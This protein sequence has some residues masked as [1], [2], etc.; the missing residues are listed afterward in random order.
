MRNQSRQRRI[1][2][3]WNTRHRISPIRLASVGLFTFLQT[4]CSLFAAY[5]SARG[6]SDQIF[7]EGRLA[8]CDE[9]PNCVSTQSL[10]ADHKIVPFTYS[11]PAA[12]AAVALKSELLRQADA[13]LIKEEGNY[14]HF[15]F[16]T[17]VMRTI[18]DVEFYFDE[19]TKTVQFR[20]SSRF[21][22]SDWGGNR[23]RM[24]DIRNVILGHI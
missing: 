3:A 7:L 9:R 20:S 18:D 10:S 4:G 6:P 2:Q 24:E 5:Q 21:G 1:K 14:M 11:K 22:Y 16:R 12:E 13:R 8:P 19:P 17:G 23:R 15:E